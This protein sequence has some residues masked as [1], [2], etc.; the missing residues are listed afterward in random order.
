MF[1]CSCSWVLYAL[2]SFDH[3][4]KLL[5][6]ESYRSAS[7]YCGHGLTIL[8]SNLEH[9]NESHCLP[10]TTKV[11][12]KWVASGVI[13]GL[14]KFSDIHSRYAISKHYIYSL[15]N[16]KR[17]QVKLTFRFQKSAEDKPQTSIT[18][19]QES[20]RKLRQKTGSD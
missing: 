4:S 14:P 11:E 8:H 19:S 18:R 15:C 3:H 17:G 2:T 13:L 6:K 10:K 9:I 20:Q 5:C 12:M 7:L 1:T 16:A